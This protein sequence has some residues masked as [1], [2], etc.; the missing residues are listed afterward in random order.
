MRLAVG[1][2][3][4]QRFSVFGGVALNVFVSDRRDGSD[5][6]YGFDTTIKSGDT[7][8]RIWPGFFAGIQF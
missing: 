7:T 1:W 6:A 3:Q 8:V 2:Q 5:L 4:H